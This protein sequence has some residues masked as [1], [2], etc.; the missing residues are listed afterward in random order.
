MPSPDLSVASPAEGAAITAAAARSAPAAAVGAQLASK[1]AAAAAKLPTAVELQMQDA[2]AV[3]RGEK[4]VRL[5]LRFLDPTPIN[6]SS[7]RGRDMRRRSFEKSNVSDDGSA[8]PWVFGELPA[9]SSSGDIRRASLDFSA[10]NGAR[11]SS[12]HG[13]TAAAAGQLLQV[14]L[15]VVAAAPVQQLALHHRK[16]RR[17]PSLEAIDIIAGG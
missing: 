8:G 16:G 15:E 2:A 12:I 9:S 10:G 6:S 11:S 1:A 5:H 7:S 17:L 13:N 3:L 4:L 14:H